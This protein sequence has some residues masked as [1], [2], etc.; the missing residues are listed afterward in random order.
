MKKRIIILSN[1]FFLGYY[2]AQVGINNP[3]PQTSLH[4]DGAKDN[5]ASGIP[6]G[7]QQANDVTITSEGRIGVGTISPSESLDI[8]SGNAR[9]RNINTN[10]GTGGIDRNVVADANGVLKTVDFNAYGLFHARLAADQVF[11]TP[12]VFSHYYSPLLC[13]LL[14]IIAIIRVREY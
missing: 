10:V 7:T 2:S 9:I 6:S 14:L 3:N 8:F 4:I 5:P 12:G 1:L 11:S 13:Q